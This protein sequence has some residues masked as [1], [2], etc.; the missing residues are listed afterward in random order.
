MGIYLKKFENHTQYE[1]YINDSGAIL[2]NVSICTIEGDVHYNP[3]VDPYNGH[4]YVDLGLPSGTLWAK[5]DV[6]ATS[7]SEYGNEYEWGAGDKTYQ[8]TEGHSD[9]PEEEDGYLVE[10]ADTAIQVWGGSWHMPTQTQFAELKEST[11]YEWITDFNGSGINGGKFTSKTDTTNYVFFPYGTY[12]SS[13]NDGEYISFLSVDEP[14]YN[15]NTG[16][17]SDIHVP[18]YIRPVIG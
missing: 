10:S 1:T 13:Y 9:W 4:Q 16:G 11:T 12:W 8:E 3:F 6:G 17:N 7:E 18:A 15:C 2:P 5:Y 14:P